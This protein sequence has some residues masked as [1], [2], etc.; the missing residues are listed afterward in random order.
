[1]TEKMQM[2]TDMVS[3]LAVLLQED[4][5]NMSMENALDEVFNSVTYQKVMDPKTTLYYQS[6]RY[7]Y[8]FLN[9]EICTGKC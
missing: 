8:S 5:P 4:H 6:P 9:D 1:M 3:W 2:Q 7:V